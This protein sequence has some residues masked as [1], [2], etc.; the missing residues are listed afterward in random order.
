MKT[1][2]G[3]LKK[4]ENVFARADRHLI[5]PD[6]S[7]RVQVPHKHIPAQNLYYQ[8][9]SLNA[10]YLVIGYLDPLGV[11]RSTA[12][13]VGQPPT[14]T[15]QG[16]SKCLLAASCCFFPVALCKGVSFGRVAGLL[17]GLLD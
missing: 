17:P 1:A 16:G 12:N 13:K 8:D 3:V 11:K 4:P 9:Y 15:V 5:V 7:L 10:K 14:F 6:L 2:G